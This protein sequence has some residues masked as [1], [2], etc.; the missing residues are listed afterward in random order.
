MDQADAD[1]RVFRG[2]MTGEAFRT[3]YRAVLTARAAKG[4]HQAGEFPGDEC[5]YMRIDHGIDMLH[6]FKN[7]SVIFKESH[8]RLIPS[9]K[10]FIW[11][12]SPRIV[13]GP[14]VKDITSPIAGRIVWCSF[15]E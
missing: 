13:Y 14:T 11:F 12:I 4:D 3:I 2:Y 10:L 15:L 1:M 7:F 8:Y 6:E 5:L 9:G